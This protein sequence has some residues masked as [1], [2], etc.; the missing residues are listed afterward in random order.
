MRKNDLTM[1]RVEAETCSYAEAEEIELEV[2]DFEEAEEAVFTDSEEEPSALDK[3]QKLSAFSQTK[4]KKGYG[5]YDVASEE[6]RKEELFDYPDE[7]SRM[8]GKCADE[9]LMLAEKERQADEDAEKLKELGRVIVTVSTIDRYSSLL[10]SIRFVR[11]EEQ[12]EE[13]FARHG[14]SSSELPAAKAYAQIKVANQ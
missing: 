13:I 7:E 8:L 11:T 10:Q 14:M 12:I 2:S 4:G 6:K 1:L 9:L 5:V 3:L